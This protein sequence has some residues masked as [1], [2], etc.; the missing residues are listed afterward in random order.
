MEGKLLE[1]LAK[2]T[3]IGGLSLG[4]LLILYKIILEKD[5]FS[6]VTKN[7]THSLFK[8]SMILIWS[9]ALVG[10]SGWMIL[11]YFSLKSNAE[12]VQNTT[13]ITTEGPDSPIIIQPKE[14]ININY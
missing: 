2:I 10:I 5:I 8:L 3:G 14:P 4:V 1:S 11:E 6:Q 7:Q 13:K 12:P 9:I